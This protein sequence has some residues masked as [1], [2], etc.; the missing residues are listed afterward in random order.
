MNI[1]ELELDKI[2]P[3]KNN[4]RKNDQAVDAVAA[5][6]KE[7]GFKVPI[8]IDQ[9]GVIIAGHT[10]LKAAKK[11]GLDKV[12]AIMA[13]D[14]TDE[15]VRAFRLADNKVGELS[16]W[17]FDK[18]ERELAEITVD[19]NRFGFTEEIEEE[20]EEIVEQD[21]KSSD[22]VTLSFQLHEKQKK[23]IE[24]AMGEVA[25][26]ITETFGN[27]NKNGNAIYEV[28]RQWAAARK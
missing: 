8:V 10:R 2:K 1:I 16:G 5:S 28:V 20:T 27:T 9:N 15:Q 22:I 21:G 4:P 6:I 3:Y 25:D 26:E 17:K 18:L 19:M 11:L 13:D 23:L 24:W 12:P 7:F 14:L